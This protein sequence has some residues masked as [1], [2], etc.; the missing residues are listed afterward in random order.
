MRLKEY[1]LEATTS[2]TQGATGRDMRHRPGPD[3]VNWEFV[4]TDISK[5][6]VADTTYIPMWTGFPY[7]SVVIDVYSRR[8]VGWSFGN[9]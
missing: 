9:R 8:M 2:L 1:F 5:L 6:W 7:L 3:L 4:A